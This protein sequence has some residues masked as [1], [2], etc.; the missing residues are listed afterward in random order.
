MTLSIAKVCTMHPVAALDFQGETP[1]CFV[2]F[3]R[4]PLPLF[5]SLIMLLLLDIQPANVMFAIDE[6]TYFRGVEEE[7]TKP[8][9]RKICKDGHA[10]FSS[11]QIVAEVEHP[12]LCDFGEA[13]FGQ[14]RPG[15]AKTSMRST[16]CQTC[17]APRRFSWACR[18][19]TRLTYGPLGLIVGSLA[20]YDL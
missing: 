17:I 5:S 4:L 8:S 3:F 9:P 15:S 13:R 7:L 16:S 14:V 10:I 19:Q 20:L 1:C 18:G 2:G 11:R 12:V 6:D